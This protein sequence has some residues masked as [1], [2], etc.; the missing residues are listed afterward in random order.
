[1]A[2]ITVTLEDDPID[3]GAHIHIDFATPLPD[4]PRD[5]SQAE[6]V[7]AE[8]LEAVSDDEPDPSTAN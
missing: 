3:G 7:L 1:M 2:K 4:N 5:Y 6:R 8:M